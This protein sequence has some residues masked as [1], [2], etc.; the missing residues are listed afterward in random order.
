VVDPSTGK[1]CECRH[2]VT[3]HIAGHTKEK[4]QTSFANELGR[5]A[6]GVDT[7]MPHG[8]NTIHF[9]QKSQIPSGKMPTYGRIEVSLRPQKKKLTAPD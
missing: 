1:C 2:L 9:I 4:W 3:G 7:R 8:T 5:L 6:Q